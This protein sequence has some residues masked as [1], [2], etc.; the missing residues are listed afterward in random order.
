MYQDSIRMWDQADSFHLQ[1]V[2]EQS[3]KF[4]F[5]TTNTD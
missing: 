3:E 5:K 2:C 4:N 1:G